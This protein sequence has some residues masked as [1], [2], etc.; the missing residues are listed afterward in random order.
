MM[1]YPFRPATLAERR[2]F[3]EKEFS[4]RKLKAYFKG[5]P[6]QLCALDAGTE[7]GIIINKKLKGFMLYCKFE[8]LMEKIR[9]YVPEDVYYDRNRYGDPEEALR[10]LKFNQWM[11]Q[12]LVFDVDTDN[13]RCTCRKVCDTCL[14][15]A[16]REAL[17]L[18]G[19]LHKK[20]QHTKI[21]YSG[22]GFHIHVLDKSAYKLSIP[23]REQL[24]KRFG[25]F[26]IDP[27][28]SRG[29]IRLIRMPYSLNALVS[30]TVVPIR[31]K[32]GNETVPKFLKLSS[33]S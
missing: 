29:Y 16:Y 10:T 24:N 26:P 31:K 27:W 21:L 4:I 32:P 11:T 17:K 3:Y 2:A 9:Q 20:F 8:N 6:P 13:I 25:K 28:V 12:E 14:T 19:E 15:N 5:K 1:Q 30:R 33:V 7:T 22:R 23:E 18:N